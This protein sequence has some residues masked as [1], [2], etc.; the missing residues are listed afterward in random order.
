MISVSMGLTTGSGAR[1]K[2]WELDPQT[3]EPSRRTR[4]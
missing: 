3:F 1:E 4:A 2:L